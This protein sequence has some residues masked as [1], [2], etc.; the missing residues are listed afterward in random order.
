MASVPVGASKTPVAHGTQ[1]FAECLHVAEIVF[2][3]QNGRHV[4]SSTLKTSG[5]GLNTP[6][7]I[8]ATECL[9]F[10]P[11]SDAQRHAVSSVRE[12]RRPLIAR[13][14]FDSES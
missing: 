4:S 9:P 7:C 11:S 1:D 8:F 3:N 13:F 5:T 6:L 14:G 2:Q 10:A 12:Q